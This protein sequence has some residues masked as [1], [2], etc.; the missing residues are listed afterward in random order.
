MK[1]LL[2]VIFLC[3]SNSITNIKRIKSKMISFS[4]ARDDY[5]SWNCKELSKFPSSKKQNV[6][7]TN[8]ARAR[9]QD[10]LR[11]GNHLQLCMEAPAWITRSLHTWVTSEI[12]LCQSDSDHR[13]SAIKRSI[14]S[15]Q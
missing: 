13:S 3:Q 9:S 6:S 12:S 10:V 15:F 14:R 7:T 4:I 5:N 2:L 11:H 1:S 8:A